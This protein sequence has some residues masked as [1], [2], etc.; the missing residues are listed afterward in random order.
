MRKKRKGEEERI[1]ERGGHPEREEERRGENT[2]CEIML[3][4]PAAHS[5]LYD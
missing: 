2:T 1:E 5:L 4:G 3:Y